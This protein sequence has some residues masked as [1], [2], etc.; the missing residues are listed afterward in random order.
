MCAGTVQ[1]QS[2]VLNKVFPL[3]L[4]TLFEFIHVN[5]SRFLDL[6]RFALRIRQ[7]FADYVNIVDR[8]NYLACLPNVFVGLIH[9]VFEV[10]LQLRVNFRNTLDLILNLLHVLGFMVHF[11]C[12]LLDL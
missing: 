2:D 3:L 7:F 1:F 11:G 5:V 9:L 12:H 6:I 8:V 10:L 4:V